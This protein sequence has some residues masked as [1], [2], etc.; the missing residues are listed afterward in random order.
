[1]SPRTASHRSGSSCQD[2]TRACHGSSGKRTRPSRSAVGCLRRWQ[3]CRRRRRP[4]IRRARPTRRRSMASS[5][6]KRRRRRPEPCARSRSRRRDWRACCRGSPG[7]STNI[8]RMRARAYEKHPV[9]STVSPCCAR[10][11]HVARARCPQARA[12]GARDPSPIQSGRGLLDTDDASRRQNLLEPGSGPRPPGTRLA[13]SQTW[14][15]ATRHPRSGNPRRRGCNAAGFPI[16]ALPGG[17]GN[18]PVSRS[19]A[20]HEPLRG[21]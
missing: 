4:R 10:N 15:W 1:M 17:A 12:T 13:R 7:S 16:D 20:T 8:L 11:A 14:R 21:R 3:S 6:L 5:E 19:V 2:I 18:A 9:R